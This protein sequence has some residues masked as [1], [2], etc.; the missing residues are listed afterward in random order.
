MRGTQVMLAIV[1]PQAFTDGVD[2]VKPVILAHAKGHPDVGQ[3][4][5][6]YNI[7]PR[8]TLQLLLQVRNEYLVCIL[9]ES[10]NA[11][12]NNNNNN[13]GIYRALLK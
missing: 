2:V 1:V 10:T 4:L 3:R 13:T 12:G 8:G 9:I 11:C 7:Q 5:S 6:R